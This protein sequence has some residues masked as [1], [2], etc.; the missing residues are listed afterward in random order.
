M[1]GIP[2]GPPPGYPRPKFV[3]ENLF[4]LMAV[5]VQS[6]LIGYV[7]AYASPMGRSPPKCLFQQGKLYV[8]FYGL[9]DLYLT[10]LRVNG[11]YCLAGILAVGSGLSSPE[12]WPPVF[13]PLKDSYTVRKFWGLVNA[14]FP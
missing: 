11:L 13:G 7:F 12:L 8:L 6:L 2:A 10:Y 9:I 4:R 3:L 1:K 14:G 5:S